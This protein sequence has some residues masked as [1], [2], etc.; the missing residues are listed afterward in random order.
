MTF[1]KEEI[2]KFDKEK[3]GSFGDFETSSSYELNYL[4]TTLDIIALM[5]IKSIRNILIS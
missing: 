4:M 1:I 2:Q 3:I 5:P